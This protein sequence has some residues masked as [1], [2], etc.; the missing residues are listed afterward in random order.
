MSVFKKLKEFFILP[1]SKKVPTELLGEADQWAIPRNSIN[2]Q[3]FIVSAGVGRSITFEE[4]IIKKFDATVVLLDPSPTGVETMKKKNDTRNI[5]FLEMGLASQAGEV[6]FGLPDRADEG[7]FRKGGKGDGIVF[8]CI[9]LAD[10]LARYGKNK[11]DLLKIDVE[12]FEYEIIESIFEKNLEVEQICVEIHHNKVIAIDKTL[13]DAAL[14]ILK[15][16]KHGYRIVYNKNMDFTF[17][18]QQLLAKA[19]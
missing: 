1:F 7:S 19:N 6:S 16:F 18:K 5:D 3:S 4:A 13:A 2:A 14:L 11:I 8:E 9:S 12:G 15:L 17:S 10:L